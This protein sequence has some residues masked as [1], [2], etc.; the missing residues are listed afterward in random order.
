MGLFPLPGIDPLPVIFCK[1]PAGRTLISVSSVNCS[2]NACTSTFT[3]PVPI[4]GAPTNWKLTCDSLFGCS[5]TACLFIPATFSAP[6]T[7]NV[8][9]PEVDL[10]VVFDKVN[11]TDATRKALQ[12]RTPAAQIVASW[13][14]GEAAFREKRKRYLLY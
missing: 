6:V 14:G 10:F 9:V 13:K 12:A 1:P 11:G 5:D 4:A 3:V 2:P 8:A 7:F